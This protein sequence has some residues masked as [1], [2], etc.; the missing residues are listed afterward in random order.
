MPEKSLVLKTQ[1]N[2]IIDAIK[3]RGIDPAEFEWTE[4]RSGRT[5]EL[6]ISVLTH[7]PTGYYFVFDFRNGRHYI[8]RSPAPDSARDEQ[9][10]GDW[11]NARRYVLDWLSILK[12]EI[13]APDLWGALTQERALADA[14]AVS[15]MSNTS[16]TGEEQRQ[17]SERLDQIE[18]DLAEIQELNAEQ[19]AFVHQQ[20]E[21]LREALPRLGRRDWLLTTLGALFSIAVEAV[22]GPDRARELFRLAANLLG[23]LF[24]SIKMLP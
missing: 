17:I 5:M 6:V 18:S 11:D 20:F 3:G 2:Q 10:P 4:R 21:Y 15:G 1:R 19:G 14:A 16:F 13:E 8:E 24:G 7:R 9:Y 12:R 23:P 22:F